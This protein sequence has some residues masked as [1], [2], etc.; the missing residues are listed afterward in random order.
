MHYYYYGPDC[1]A[2]RAAAGKCRHGIT[3]I[4]IV[5]YIYMILFRSC[6]GSNGFRNTFSVCTF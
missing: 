6:F 4:Y 1:I 3:F 2:L 5:I